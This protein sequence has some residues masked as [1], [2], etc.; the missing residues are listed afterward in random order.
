MAKSAFVESL[1]TSD[2]FIEK[3]AAKVISLNNDGV[4]K[5]DNYSGTAEDGSITDYHNN[6]A[7]NAFME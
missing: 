7:R 1:V 4:I 2:A 3:L 5:S 6:F